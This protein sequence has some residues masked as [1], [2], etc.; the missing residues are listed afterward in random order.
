M[1]EKGIVDY[2][3]AIERA[4]KT[5]GGSKKWK[6]ASRVIS[7]VTM[8]MQRSGFWWKIVCLEALNGRIEYKRGDAQQHLREEQGGGQGLL[9]I[10]LIRVLAASSKLFTSA[11]PDPRSFR[12]VLR[13]QAAPHFCFWALMTQQNPWF[14]K[15]VNTVGSDERTALF[16]WEAN[17]CFW[18]E[19]LGRLT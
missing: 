9:R 7:S 16:F 1:K 5:L 18:G 8:A 13:P 14:S 6:E 2:R 19:Q 10:T 3:W 17:V 15:P 12:L 11:C 4:D